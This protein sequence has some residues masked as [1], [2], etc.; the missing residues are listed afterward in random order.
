MRESS[1]PVPSLTIVTRS[2][3]FFREGGGGGYV[4]G[5]PVVSKK[6]GFLD[7]SSIIIA[8]L[9]EIFRP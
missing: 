9:S 6:T 3:D 7:E 4:W 8:I 2:Q 1:P 5:F